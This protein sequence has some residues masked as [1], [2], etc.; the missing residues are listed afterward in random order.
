[1]ASEGLQLK[2]RVGKESY[3]CKLCGKRVYNKFSYRI[4]NHQY[5]PDWV[6]RVLYPVC[7]TCLYKENYGNKFYKKQMKEG[8]LDG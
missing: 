5:V 8:T 6:P 1:M 7:R 3:D 4:Q 2:D